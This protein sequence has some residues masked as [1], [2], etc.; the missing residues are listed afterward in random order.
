[1]HTRVHPLM[2][3]ARAWHAYRSSTWPSSRR[4]T[5]STSSSSSGASS[6]A[7]RSRRASPHSL[8][9][10]PS[11]SPLIP[12]HRPLR[13]PAAGRRA[14]GLRPASGCVVQPRRPT[15]LQLSGQCATPSSTRHGRVACP[16][17]ARRAPCSSTE[18]GGVAQSE[19]GH[20][21]GG[22]GPRHS[23]I[24]RAGAALG[25]GPALHGHC[26]WRHDRL[27]L[28][29]D[30]SQSQGRQGQHVAGHWRPIGTLCPGALPSEVEPPVG[31][32]QGREG[33]ASAR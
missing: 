10:L 15:Q 16:T 21:S 26:H 18:C 23:G 30:L 31:S 28:E 3:T 9:A 11:H 8:G 14:D 2:C 19:R 1:M 24:R 20:L 6:S 12:S 5:A 13:P 25:S 17:A 32:V 27:E 29:P 33:D 7:S 22:W 4:S